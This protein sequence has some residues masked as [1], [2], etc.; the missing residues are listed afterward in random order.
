QTFRKEL[1]SF[2]ELSIED[3]VLDEAWN[4]M[5]LDIPAERLQLLGELQKKKKIFLLSNTNAIHKEA[6]DKKLQQ[7]GYS[8][9]DVFFEKAYYSH[10]VGDRKPNASIFERV[11]QENQLNPQTTLFIDDTYQHIAGAKSV[12][13]QTIH[14]Q[15]PKTILDYRDWLMMDEFCGKELQ[16]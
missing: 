8:T 16:P 10:L 5:L 12:G 3:H 15:A 1:K 6:F 2:L 9:L 4:A 11:L 7:H 13:L 14:L